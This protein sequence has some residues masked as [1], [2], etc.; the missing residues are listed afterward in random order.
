MNVS[1]R[2]LL[3]TPVR[4]AVDTYLDEHLSG[5]WDKQALFDTVESARQRFATMI[6][7]ADARRDLATILGLT[8]NADALALTDSLP[9]E[10][11]QTPD[12]ESLVLLAKLWRL[13]IQAA[14]QV[15]ASAQAKLDYEYQLVWG[16]IEL[17]LA[18]EREER[19]SQGGRDVFADTA[20]AS[21][22]STKFTVMFR[23]KYRL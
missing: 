17:G 4:E 21:I 23:N 19:R 11:P 7:A 16:V 18:M 10:F 13:D 2:G 22:A 14:K 1:V 15:L 9:T 8:S 3:S 12:S 20:R 5:E 6:A